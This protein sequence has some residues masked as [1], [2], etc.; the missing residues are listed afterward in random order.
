AAELI[1]EQQALVDAA[2][3]SGVGDLSVMWWDGSTDAPSV[4]SCCGAPG[5]LMTALG[6]TNVFDDEA[7]SW[8]TVNWE[9]VIEADPDVIILVDASWDLAADKEEFLRADPVLQNLS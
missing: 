4:G 1:A 6:V 5:M 2:D 3:L 8:T 7:G 9:P